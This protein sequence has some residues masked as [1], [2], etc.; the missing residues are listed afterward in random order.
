MGEARL[1]YM[2]KN[3]LPFV[4]ETHLSCVVKTAEGLDIT[5]DDLIGLRRWIIIDS[6][7]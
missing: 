6:W 3:Y 5:L 2:V 4:V 7:M 1:S